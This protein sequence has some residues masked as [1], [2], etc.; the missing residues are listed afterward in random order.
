MFRRLLKIVGS[1]LLIIFIVG[2]LAFTSHESQNVDC[3]NIKIVFDNDELIQVSNDELIRIVKATDNTI[4][5]KKLN[6]INLEK[7]ELAI[8]KHPAILNAE[9]Y[10]IMEK[11]SGSYSGVLV[12]KV[13]HREPVVRVMSNVG[14]YYLDEFGKKIPISTNYTANVLVTTG[15]LSEKYAVEK[16]RPFVLFV[17]ND[18]FWRAQIEQV[19]IKENG[20]VVLIPL[21]GEH[22]IEFGTLDNYQKKLQKMKA[23]YQQVLAKNNWNKYKTVSLKYNNQVIAKRR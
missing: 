1:L 6:A 10:K 20:E 18:E 8:E 13:K 4:L 15:F 21:V 12:V 9:V 16:L 7:I 14:S 11:D 2:T 17:E 22:I 3:R 5:T 23:F 19:H